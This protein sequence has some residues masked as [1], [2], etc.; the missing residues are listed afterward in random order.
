MVLL[1]AEAFPAGIRQQAEAAVLAS[2][3][4]VGNCDF[5]WF[6]VTVL[7]ESVHIPE[8]IDTAKVESDLSGLSVMERQIVACLR[9]R[10]L[11]GYTRQAALQEVLVVNAPWS[12][13]FIV[14]LA[15]EYV[16]EILNDIHAALPYFESVVVA[17]FL[18]DN[19]LFHQLTRARV[20]SYWSCYYRQHFAREDYVGF[21]VLAGFDAMLANG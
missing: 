7:G 20:M 18:R 1:H 14:K 6:S 2:G 21:K 17:G 8:R 10:S 16:I 11:N 19:P 13:P 3:V 15:G 12:I 4:A 5:R 9:T